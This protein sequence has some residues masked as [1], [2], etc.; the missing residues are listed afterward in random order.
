[1]NKTKRQ[2]IRMNS[3]HA[4]SATMHSWLQQPNRNSMPISDVNEFIQQRPDCILT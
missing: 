1:M 2:Y 3:L 4:C